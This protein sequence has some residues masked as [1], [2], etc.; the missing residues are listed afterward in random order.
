[1]IS[2]L[3]ATFLVVTGLVIFTWLTAKLDTVMGDIQTG[4]ESD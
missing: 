1:M 4:E 3:V 2:L